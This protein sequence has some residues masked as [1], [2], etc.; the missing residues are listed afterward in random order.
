MVG[1]T[2]GKLTEL[3]TMEEEKVREIGSLK[4]KHEEKR[5]MESMQH[6]ED[7]RM[8]VYSYCV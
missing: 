2:L 1:F 8:G 3:S 6:Q 5:G 4:E 7:E